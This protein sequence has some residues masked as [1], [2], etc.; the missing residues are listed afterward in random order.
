M[1]NYSVQGADG[2]MY[3]PVDDQGLIE[4]ARQGRVDRSSNVRV[5]ENGA[6]YMAAALPV[7]AGHFATMP[8]AYPGNPAPQAGYAA[9]PTYAQPGYVPP[10]YAQQGYGQ[11]YALPGQLNYAVPINPGAYPISFT[12]FPVVAVVLLHLLTFGIFSV[13]WF[14]L[15]HDKMPQ[16]RPNDP[17]AAKGVGFCFIPYFHFYWVCFTLI[18]LEDRIEEQRV[19]RGL[20]PARMKG[21]VTTSSVLFVI[22][23]VNFFCIPIMGSILAGRLQSRANEL[24]RFSTTGYM[25]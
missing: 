2:Q 5:E 15:M 24:A 22:P 13:V 7:L 23:Y 3:G 10:E 14:N 21:F 20:P 9:G 25:Q 17:S 11:A 12:T 8:Q 19:A 1:A 18:R 16:I 6:M 4:W